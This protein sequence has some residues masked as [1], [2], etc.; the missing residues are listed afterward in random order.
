MSSYMHTSV[1]I[2]FFY[3]VNILGQQII[4]IYKKFVFGVFAGLIPNNLLNTWDIQI[5]LISSTIQIFRYLNI[6][7]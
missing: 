4:I 1:T 2:F 6:N 5:Q 3:R 7:S